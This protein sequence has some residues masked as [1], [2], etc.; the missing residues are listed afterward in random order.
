[1]CFSSAASFGA[2]AFL[3]VAG[4]ASIARVRHQREILFAAIPVIFAIQQVAEGMIWLSM[5]NLALRTLREDLTYFFLFVAESVWPVWVP[6]SLLLV[7]RSRSRKALLIALL[8][9]GLSTSVYLAFY[10]LTYGVEATVSDCH[11]LYLQHLRSPYSVL[12]SLPY[13][14]A[15]ILP[16]FVSG[17]RA[18][19]WLGI[20][21]L[22]SYILTKAFYD[23]ELLSM[24]CFYAGL[25]SIFIYGIMRSINAKA[26]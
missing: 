1:M 4:I 17:V 23:Y 16:F 7:E 3:V 26:S 5:G 25:I 10:L 14:S 22:A 18:M 21:V 12:T 13:L 6:L 20:V 15:T 19:R 8:I 2:A 9:T 24:W 11:I